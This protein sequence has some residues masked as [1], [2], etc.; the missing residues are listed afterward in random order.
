MGNWLKSCEGGW[1]VG[2]VGTKMTDEDTKFDKI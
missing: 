1:E 2:T